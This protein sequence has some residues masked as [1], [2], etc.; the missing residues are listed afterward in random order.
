MFFIKTR[1]REGRQ[2]PNI[3]KY[4]LD[5]QYFE[6]MITSNCPITNLLKVTFSNLEGVCLQFFRTVTSNTMLKN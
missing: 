2:I 4:L 3:S 6:A 1:R 5:A